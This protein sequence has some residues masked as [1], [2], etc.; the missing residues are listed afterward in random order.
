MSRV[1]PEKS[2]CVTVWEN[3]VKETHQRR[4]MLYSVADKFQYFRDDNP[5]FRIE[6]S[7]FIKNLN[8]KLMLNSMM[9]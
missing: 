4:L 1:Q 8:Q 9:V 5:H 7:K 3:K 2:D 6:M